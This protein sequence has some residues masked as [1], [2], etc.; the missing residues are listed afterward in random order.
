M[1]CIKPI[2]LGS[3]GDQG[4]DSKE[5]M[6]QKFATE[7]EFSSESTSSACHECLILTSLGESSLSSFDSIL[8]IDSWNDTLF[9]M[10]F[11]FLFLESID[12]ANSMFEFEF[13]SKILLLCT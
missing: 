8:R 13:M 3:G 5:N 2:S 11:L 10:F 7:L 4:F 1:W 9:L 12:D 6:A